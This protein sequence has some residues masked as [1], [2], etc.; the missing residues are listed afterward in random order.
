MTKDLEGSPKQG[1]IKAMLTSA[2]GHNQEAFMKRIPACAAGLVAALVIVSTTHAQDAPDEEA[3]ADDA[4]IEEALSAAPADIA[5]NAAVMDWDGNTLREGTNGYTCFPTP[6]TLAGTSPM[7]LDEP[8]MGWAEAWQGETEPQIE[9]TGVA[10][11]LRGDEGASNTDPYAMSPEEVD[12]WVVAGPHLMIVTPD[13][14]T[15][16]GM[17]TDP[18]AGTPWVMWQGTPYA[19]VMVPV[20][21]P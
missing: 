3:A 14:A 21:A 2:Q 17:N 4:V 11:M 18:D 5:E 10:Y 12:D 15:L 16:A 20:P 13:P 9:R 8:W 19:H 7:C 6:P 1:T